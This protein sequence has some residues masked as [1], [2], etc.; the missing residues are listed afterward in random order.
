MPM[1]LTKMV[2][3]PSATMVPVPTATAVR[4]GFRPTIPGC[5]NFDGRVVREVFRAILL[6][7]AIFPE[8]IYIGKRRQRV[9][10]NSELTTI[11]V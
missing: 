5:P 6:R 9:V 11:V 1:P 4:K 3:P 8:A 7:R 2:L 10:K